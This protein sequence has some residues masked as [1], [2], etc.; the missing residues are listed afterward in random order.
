MPLSTYQNNE[1]GHEDE[2]WVFLELAII[3]APIAAI[4][5]GIV[6]SCFGG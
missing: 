6:T 4:L 2:H 3:F 1:P 5:I